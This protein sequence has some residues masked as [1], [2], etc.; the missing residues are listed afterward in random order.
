VNPRSYPPNRQRGYTL[1][2][3]LILLLVAILS[4][5]IWQ[6]FRLNTETGLILWSLAAVGAFFPLTILIY[7]MYALSRGDYLLD[8]ETLTIRWGLRKELIP[9]SDVEWVRP[10]GDLTHQVRLPLFSMPGAVVGKRHHRDLNS[11]EFLAGDSTNLLLVATASQV[12]AIS[13]ADPT[14]FMQDFQRIVEMGSLAASSQQSEFPSFIVIKAWQNRL[15]RVLWLVGIL[16]NIGLLV[17]V[18]LLIPTLKSIPL[19]FLSSGLPRSIVPGVQLL[20]LPII[21]ILF[22]IVIWVAGMY[23]FRR[24]HLRILAFNLWG[25]S[26]LSGLFFLLAVL[27]IVSTPS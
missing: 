5:C 16:S 10:V 26:A 14:G 23:Y 19:G 15:V 27:F 13:P 4:L 25:F 2:F 17:W 18:S 6:A 21:S 22:S 24:P 8:R 1:H 12:F 11:V 7:R 20:L 3:F 9:V